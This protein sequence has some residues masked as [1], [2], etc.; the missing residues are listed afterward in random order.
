MKSYIMSAVLTHFPETDLHLRLLVWLSS[1]TAW[2]F[3]VLFLFYR[4]L[5][6]Q[7]RF[8]VCTLASLEAGCFLCLLMIC[9][10]AEACAEVLNPSLW[11]EEPCSTMGCLCHAVPSCCAVSSTTGLYSATSCRVRSCCQLLQARRAAARSHPRAWQQGWVEWWP[12]AS[13]HPRSV[14]KGCVSISSWTADCVRTNVCWSHWAQLPR[15]YPMPHGMRREILFLSVLWK[16]HAVFPNAVTVQ[17][18]NANRFSLHISDNIC[19]ARLL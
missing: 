17:F 19:A 14:C 8:G 18:L 7:N 9:S 16:F 4:S 2:R 3:C 12:W 10:L 6:N 11:L 1:L 15:K 5:W 13:R